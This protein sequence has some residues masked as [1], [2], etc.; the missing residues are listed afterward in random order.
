MARH[1]ARVSG[2]LMLACPVCATPEGVVM[3]DGA[4]SGALVLLGVTLLVVIP[5]MAAALQLWRR[6]AHRP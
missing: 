2:R 4:R 3:T 6:E 1:L 5:L